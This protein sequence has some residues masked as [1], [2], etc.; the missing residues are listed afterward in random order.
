M[1]NQ[2]SQAKNRI[3]AVLAGYILNLDNVKKVL[4]QQAYLVDG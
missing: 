2:R 1:V 3:H 4:L